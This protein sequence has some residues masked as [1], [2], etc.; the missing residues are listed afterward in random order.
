MFSESNLVIGLYS[1]Y[2]AAQARKGNFQKTYYKNL[3]N[4]LTP[5]TVQSTSKR[6]VLCRLRD[7]ASWLPLAVG[8]SSRNLGHK[9]LRD[10]VH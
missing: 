2:H 1:S 9:F 6:L 4:K 3:R 8:E 5:Q 10:S 7:P